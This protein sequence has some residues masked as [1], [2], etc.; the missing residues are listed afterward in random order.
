MPQQEVRKML[1][2]RPP[3]S[4]SQGLLALTFADPVTT[5]VFAPMVASILRGGRR[6]SPAESSSAA[7]SLERITNVT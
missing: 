4:K 6:W 3:V 5:S 2:V 7:N 1:C